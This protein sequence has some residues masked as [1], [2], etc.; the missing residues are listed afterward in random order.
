MIGHPNITT[1]DELI[2]EL[3]LTKELKLVY[4]QEMY[5]FMAQK[6]TNVNTLNQDAPV[7]LR[8]DH[9]LEIV[10]R[11]QILPSQKV[12]FLIFIAIMM[13]QGIT[14]NRKTFAMFCLRMNRKEGKKIFTGQT[15][16]YVA[17]QKTFI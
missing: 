17:E 16:F 12:G 9:V 2:S 1:G 3:A 4:Y 14:A 5:D 13:K 7:K 15:F 6:Q 10:F 11:K 8:M